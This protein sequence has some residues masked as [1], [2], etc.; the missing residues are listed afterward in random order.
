[1][2][3]REEI[4]RVLSQVAEHSHKADSIPRLL[5]DKRLDRIRCSLCSQFMQLFSNAGQ[6]FQKGKYFGVW[7]MVVPVCHVFAFLA[8]IR[9]TDPQLKTKLQRLETQKRAA[10][11]SE[12]EWD[13]T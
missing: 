8:E 6:S 12:A 10:L 5:Q 2:E 11:D 1:M 3:V 13:N 9:N 7:C 4:D